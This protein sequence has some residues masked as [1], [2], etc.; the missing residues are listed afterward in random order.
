[1]APFVRPR[2]VQASDAGLNDYPYSPQANL[3]M[4]A[5]DFPGAQALPPLVARR[6]RAVLAE[7]WAPSISLF[8]VS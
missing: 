7:D 6:G 1:M 8:R 2:H 4:S 3:A 5:M